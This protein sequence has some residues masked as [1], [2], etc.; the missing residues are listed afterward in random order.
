MSLLHAVDASV[1]S[2]LPALRSFDPVMLVPGATPMSPEYTIVC[3]PSK[4]IVDPAW[5]AKLL[6]LPIGILTAFAFANPA[7][8]MANAASRVEVI[9]V[10]V[11]YV[12][13]SN[14]TG[15]QNYGT[16]TLLSM[17]TYINSGE[18]QR[19]PLCGAQKFRIQNIDFK[20]QFPWELE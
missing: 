18:S 2:S 3:L 16:L 13:F 12:Q 17:Y 11:S 10:G 15:D 7:I 8:A 9:L 19:G 6:Q 14:V 1:V 4:V 5:R 20:F